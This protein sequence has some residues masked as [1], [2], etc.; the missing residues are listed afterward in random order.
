MAA[1]QTV[2][3]SLVVDL[4]VAF[5]LWGKFLECISKNLVL[6]L[7]PAQLVQ[8][9]FHVAAVGNNLPLLLW[10]E[11]KRASLRPCMPRMAFICFECTLKGRQL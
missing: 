5:F 4:R 3:H 1:H 10:S 7:G 11:C 8:L 2:T 9:V 6:N